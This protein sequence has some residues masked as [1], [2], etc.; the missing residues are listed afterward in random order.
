MWASGADIAKIATTATDIVDCARVLTLLKTSQGNH[1]EYH[2]VLV[3]SCCCIAS[4]TVIASLT[5]YMLVVMSGLLMLDVI[6]EMSLIAMFVLGLSAKL[7]Q[8]TALVLLVHAKAQSV[9]W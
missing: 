9:I 8:L 3:H 1:A 7:L 4:R 5:S 2:L 6:L